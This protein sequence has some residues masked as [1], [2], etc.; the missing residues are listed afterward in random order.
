M[1]LVE[2]FERMGSHD[3]VLQDDRKSLIEC[4]DNGGGEGGIVGQMHA[5]LYNRI[6]I[7]PL[8]LLSV[9]NAQPCSGY[10]LQ[11]Q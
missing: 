2:F 5:E 1:Q 10:K 9:T 6:S 7:L 8:V 11:E 3:S 4:V